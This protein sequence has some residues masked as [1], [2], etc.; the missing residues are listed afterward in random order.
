M[1]SEANNYIIELRRQYLLALDNDAKNHSQWYLVKQDEINNLKKEAKTK[2]INNIDDLKNEKLDYANEYSKKALDEINEFKVNMKLIKSQPK[3]INKKYQ[4]L[5][6]DNITRINQEYID[7]IERVKQE[8]Q[9][10]TLMCKKTNNMN[11]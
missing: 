7:N 6:D 9:E 5:A 3:A 8:E 11:C 10:R 4:K 2:Y 1:Y